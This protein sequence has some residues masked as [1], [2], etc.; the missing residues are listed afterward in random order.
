GTAVVT[1]V[2]TSALYRLLCEVFGGRHVG[3]PLSADFGFDV[4]ALVRA[5][6]AGS[7][8]VIVV[9]TPNNP[10][11]TPFPE[12]GIER[13]LEETGA[14]IVMDEAYQDFGG[15]SAVPLLA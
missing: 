4:A 10:T 7:G 8:R 11:G 14:L 2:P 15:P 5:A 1:P 3:V 9:N 6:A 12:G 13:L